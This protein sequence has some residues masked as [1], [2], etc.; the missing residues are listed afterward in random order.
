[1]PWKGFFSRL[2]ASLVLVYATFNP[3]GLS[4]YHWA[5]APLVKELSSFDALKF[6]AG[7]ILIAGW[8]VF[9]QATKRSIGWK[10]AL[11]V[12]A[13]CGGL[14]W[15]LA[16]WHVVNAASS[17]VLTHLGL[18]VT[19]IILTIG[20]SWSHVSRKLTGQTDTD[21]VS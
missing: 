9:I 13:V 19:A 1:M 18:L 20:M 2:L 10:G 4:Y 14:I 6:L 5:L 12:A 8:V 7:V 21:I 17:M 16:E 3:T 15:L 11:L